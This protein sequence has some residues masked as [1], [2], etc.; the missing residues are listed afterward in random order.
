MVFIVGGGGYELTNKEPHP[1][2]V[3]QIEVF[4]KNSDILKTLGFA[5]VLA[6]TF[7]KK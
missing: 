2:F 1:S 5:L 3:N 7:H 6:K 4:K